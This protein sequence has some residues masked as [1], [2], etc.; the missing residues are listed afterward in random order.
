MKI[1]IITVAGISS[2]FNDGIREGQ[3]CLK[4]IYSEGMETDTLL[5]HL[6]KKCNYADRVIVVGGY[7]FE[8]LKK[9]IAEKFG[10]EKETKITLVYNG[11]YMDLASGYSLYLGLEEAFRY[12]DIEEILFV[13]GDL[14]IDDRSFK[15]VVNTAGDVFT[16]H[17]GPIRASQDVLFYRSGEGRYRYLFNSMHGLLQIREPFSHIYN[18]GQLWKL[19][20][21][22]KLREANKVFYKKDKKGTNLMIIQEYL[23]HICQDEIKIVGLK[24]WTNCNTREDYKKIRKY[25]EEER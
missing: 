8:E 21:A 5:V 14:D 2:R 16:Y 10:G 20:D 3:K 7:Q 1:A 23:D 25:W 17:S 13:E 12:S 15:D 22:G 6:I 4:A 9:Y 24:R 19:V 18:S 11:H